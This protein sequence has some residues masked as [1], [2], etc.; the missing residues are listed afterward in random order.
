MQHHSMREVVAAVRSSAERRGDDQ[1]ASSATHTKVAAAGGAHV[2][3]VARDTSA[4]RSIQRRAARTAM[5]L[6]MRRWHIM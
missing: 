5:T 6:A 4:P 2:G 1:M 3:A